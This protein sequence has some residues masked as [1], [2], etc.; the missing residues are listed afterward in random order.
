MQLLQSRRERRVAEG[1][2]NAGPG[3]L[4]TLPDTV[5]LEKLAYRFAVVGFIFWTFTLI[6]G[7]IW[8]YFACQAPSGK[9]SFSCSTDRCVTLPSK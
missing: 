8:A 4:R 3:F 6:A 1:I 2:A 5:R 9:S 7:S